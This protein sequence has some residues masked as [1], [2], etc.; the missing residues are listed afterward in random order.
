MA[1]GYS[2]P[3]A[4]PA[5]VDTE[6]AL[7]SP[8]ASPVFTGSIQFPIRAV[9]AVGAAT[10]AGQVIVVS[11]SSPNAYALCVA[12]GTNWID[13]TTNTTVSAT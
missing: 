6:L 9:A 12:N 13:Q 2:T 8:L 7:K 10:T 3:G 11:N 1:V 4:E 5:S